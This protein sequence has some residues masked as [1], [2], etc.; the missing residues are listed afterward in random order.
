MH[1]PWNEVK[2]LQQPLSDDAPKIAIRD[3][4]KKTRSRCEARDGLLAPNKPQTRLYSPFQ[5]VPQLMHARIYRSLGTARVLA[6]RFG[7]RP[8]LVSRSGYFGISQPEHH[9]TQIHQGLIQHSIDL[10]DVRHDPLLIEELIGGY[11][12]RS[13]LKAVESEYVPVLR[14]SNVS[15]QRLPALLPPKSDVSSM[16]EGL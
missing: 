5:F 8:M 2:A 10:R 1:A 15:I 14:G 6:N 12:R 3:P 9:R 11:R 4:D 16:I 7:K 13:D